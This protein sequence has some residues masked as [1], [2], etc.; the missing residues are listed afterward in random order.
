[1]KATNQKM[2]NRI[3]SLSIGAILLSLYSCKKFEHKGEPKLPSC[4]LCEFADSIEG[5]YV[6]RSYGLF[7]INGSNAYHSNDTFQM[8]VTHIFLNT[9][10]AIDSTIMFF[11]L[12]SFDFLYHQVI[13]DT[14]C[15]N[16]RTGAVLETKYDTFI[17][18]PDSVYIYR[19][20][21]TPYGLLILNHHKAFKI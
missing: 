14:I 9:N 11:R 18:Q 13:V 21:Y 3:L 17:I 16:K 12:E 15:I 8:D 6:G 7:Q 10:S 19:E 4:E 20:A 5:T 1:M 2:K